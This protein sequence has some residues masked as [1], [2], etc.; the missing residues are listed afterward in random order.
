MPSLCAAVQAAVCTESRGQPRLESRWLDQPSE[1]WIAWSAAVGARAHTLHINTLALVQARGPTPGCLPTRARWWVTRGPRRRRR[2]ARRVGSAEARRCE[3][4]GV[5]FLVCH[6]E[7]NNDKMSIVRVPG[8]GAG[9]RAREG[10][11]ARGG[12]SAP[13]AA[14]TNPNPGV[15]GGTNKRWAIFPTPA[16][17]PC[18]QPLDP[19][20][21]R[22]PAPNPVLA[23]LPCP[24]RQFLAP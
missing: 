18:S 22:T 1:V 21:W 11:G 7:V 13:P 14:P 15:E 16:P 12:G 19:A 3:C 5:G 23:T 2:S 24:P 4:G 17:T 6:L 10:G 8:G 9:L 20:A